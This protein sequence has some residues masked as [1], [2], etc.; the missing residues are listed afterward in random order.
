MATNSQQS[1]SSI[2]PQYD[3][4]PFSSC[5]DR[6]QHIADYFGPLG[7]QALSVYWTKK[8]EAIT[9]YMEGSKRSDQLRELQGQKDDV[10]DLLL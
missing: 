2:P 4:K 1:L 9:R 8:A 3:I 5:I 6:T 7:E 10:H